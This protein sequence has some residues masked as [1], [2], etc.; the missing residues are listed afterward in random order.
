M[1]GQGGYLTVQRFP[2]HPPMAEVIM[3]GAHEL[4]YEVKNSLNDFN[5]TGFTIAHATVRN[6]QRLSVARAFLYPVICRTNL[7]IIPHAYVSIFSIS[8]KFYDIFD[9]IMFSSHY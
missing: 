5:Q 7:K 8:M 3:N 2:Y 9:K 6:G 1:Y 4:G